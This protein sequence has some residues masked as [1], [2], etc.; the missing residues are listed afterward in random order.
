[1]KKMVLLA[2]IALLSA[3][4]FAQKKK[5]SAKK[6]VATAGYAKVDNLVAEVKSGNFQVTINEN[7]KPKDAMIVKAAD[8]SFTPLECKLSSFTAGGT[9]LYLL[10]W[11]EKSGSKTDLK[12]EDITTIYSV[13]Y[14]ITA[15]KQVFS[16]TQMTNHITE[17]VYLNHT[18]ASET[19][20]KIRREGFE[21][22]LNPDGSI[23]QKGKTQENKFAYDATKAEYVAAKKK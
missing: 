7:G 17:K 16:N 9:K 5:T 4:S 12:T 20:E 11:S 3:N 23:T 6:V 21:F 10:T 14:E 15:K 13:V 22:K 8:A 2:F 19:Q 18:A 1:M